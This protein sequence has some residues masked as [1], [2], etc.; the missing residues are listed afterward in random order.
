MTCPREVE[1]LN[2]NGLPSDDADGRWS[3]CNQ[4]LLMNW[5]DYSMSFTCVVPHRENLLVRA[6][7]ERKKKWKRDCFLCWSFEIKYCVTCEEKK[8]SR[9][10]VKHCCCTW[11]RNLAKPMPTILRLP[12]K[13]V[14]EEE[15]K[16]E[17]LIEKANSSGNM[18]AETRKRNEFCKRITAKS[19]IRNEVVNGL[20]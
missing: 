9:L 2:A 17:S 4:M 3:A 11:C 16:W 13:A 18:R 14:G 15:N 20:I 8:A 5:P 7:F 19:S 12:V 1:N 10:R 6:A